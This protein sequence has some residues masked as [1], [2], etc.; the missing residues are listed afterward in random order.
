[1]KEVLK[2]K[3]IVKKA[4][5]F[6]IATLLILESG[7]T[8]I[9]KKA[10][11]EE[12]LVLPVPVYEFTFEEETINGVQV[13][14]SDRAT[15]VGVATLGGN[16]V[17]VIHDEERDSQVLNL[18]GGKIDSGYLTLPEDLFR[19][20]MDGF[21]LC[22]WV[23]AQADGTSGTHYQRI[24][25]SSST[26]LGKYNQGITGNWTDP[27]FSVVIGG[28]DTNDSNRYDGVI[29]TADRTKS[30]LGF[31]TI[32]GKGKWQYVTLSVSKTSYE[33]YVN[34]KKITISDLS[35]NMTETL[36][37][38]FVELS[39]FKYNSLGQSVYTSD[40]NAK[41]KIDDFRFYDTALTEAEAVSIYTEEYGLEVEEPGEYEEE[42]T[43]NF[44]LTKSLGEM[45]H[46]STGF[47]YGVSENNVPSTDLIGAIKPKFLVQKAADGKQ[48]PSGDAYR[49]T[50]Y[51]KENG[52][53]NLQVYLQDY[54]LQWPYDFHGIEDYKEKVISIV[55]KMTEGKTEEEKAFYSYVLFNEP[56]MI[57]YGNSGKKLEEF[58][59][60]W[61]TIYKAIKEIDKN[62][63]VAGPNFAGYH[64]AAYETF[65][66]FCKENDCLPE[67][68]TWHD[69]QKDKLTRF[70][71]E[72]EHLQGLIDT[73][74]AG[75]GIEPTLFVNEVAN[76]EDVG[77]PGPLVNW[78]SI[79]EEKDVYAALP[80]WGLANTL[81]ELA[82]DANKPNGAWWV[83]KWYADMQGEKV[84]MVKENQGSGAKGDILYGL[85]SVDKEEQMI[86][87]LF[88]GHDGTQVIRLKNI[89]EIDGFLASSN[90]N[91]KIYS[92]KYTGHHGFADD[93]PV[94]YE[95]NL[96]IVNGTLEIVL[97]DCDLLDAYF[98]VITPATDAS[99]LSV[100]DYER[101]FTKTYEAE[102]GV[103]L[104][105]AMIYN[106][107]GGADL[108]RSNR[109]EVGN[110][111]SSDDGVKYQ[112]EVPK[113]GL[114]EVEVYYSVSA[115]F[116]NPITLQIDAGG[117]NRAIGKKV[118][119]RLTVDGNEDTAQILDFVSTVKTGYYNYEKV[120]LYLTAGAHDIEV[121][122]YGESQKSVPGSIRLAA[123][124][125]KI[126]VTYVE[127][128]EVTTNIQFEEVIRENTYNFNQQ[129]SGFHGN[130]YVSGSGEFEFQTVVPEDG[131]YQVSLRS[132][133]EG[134]SRITLN[135]RAVDYA[136]DA[137]AESAIQFYPLKVGEINTETSDTFVETNMNKV[138]LTAGANTLY[139]NSESTVNL[140]E[141]IFTLDR[142]I[143]ENKTISIE[144]E[145]GVLS[146]EA[147]KENNKYASVGRVVDGIGG[148]TTANKL[149]I[150]FDAPE[151]GDYKLSVVYAN[152]EPAPM[153]KKDDGGNYVHPYNTDLIERYAQICV[154]DAEPETVYFRN[155]LSWDVFRN[156]VMDVSLNKGSN[157]ITIYNDNTYKFSEVVDDFAPQFDRFDIT[158]AYMDSNVAVSINKQTLY[159]SIL[160]ANAYDVQDYT[161][162]SYKE[163]EKARNSAYKLYEKANLKEDKIVSAI[164]QIEDAIS[165]LISIVP[166]K[167]ELE[168]TKAY[169]EEEMLYTVSSYDDLWAAVE[170]GEAVLSKDNASVHEL[171][172]CIA[173]LK[174]AVSELK[175]VEYTI[176]Y[177]NAIITTDNINPNTHAEYAWDGDTSTHPDLLTS[178]GGWDASAAWTQIQLDKPVKISKLS[179]APRSGYTNRLNGGYFEVSQDGETF[180]TI[181]MVEN[182]QDGYN[183]ATIEAET[184]YSY[185]RYHSPAHAY[186]NIS[187]IKI[188]TWILN[189]QDLEKMKK[190]LT[191]FE[192]MC[193]S[194]N[195]ASDFKVPT[196]LTEGSKVKWTSDH[197]AISINADG[198]ASVKRQK[199]VTVVNLTARVLY[200][201]VKNIF[202]FVLEVPAKSAK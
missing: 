152:N 12:S 157:H 141:I 105:E 182:A 50:S 20:E 83:Y 73:Y 125:D 22:Y 165:G 92:T 187:D 140:D 75:S 90:A 112:I 110:I 55:T 201:E 62:A 149:E 166:L 134:S 100:K 52:V 33:V 3:K 40:K 89:S 38:F 162:T 179:Y 84:E 111:L 6:G 42:P 186:L 94:L 171:E 191:E 122:H 24:F 74:Y 176:N 119:N 106:R 64:E 69:L 147:K 46:R 128:P 153:M 21:S 190:D 93:T 198:K 144:A 27:E 155:T 130:G 145:S 108:A 148:G 59:R 185:L 196:T 17:S 104:G 67:M 146:G 115:P 124:Q 70:Q 120:S 23:K 151:A 114:Y 96:P 109:A 51:L 36:A 107:T 138:Y 170:N 163:L 37:K 15:G 193:K 192:E 58:C 97:E 99:I 10:K 132:M 13:N 127:N 121:R 31:S 4:V 14:N 137:K 1:M 35:D 175:K 103:L 161:K 158:P 25:E 183:T 129:G 194:L 30:R 200:G 202:H 19:D 188:Y 118:K 131:L 54:Y 8:G 189:A 79:Y 173:I 98:A 184:E 87:S 143:T 28:G 77:A 80:Y 117:Q 48:H 199:N 71:S 135:K 160:T 154:N 7:M 123:S 139:L 116:V 61:L 53:E 66:K 47:L 2:L 85:T 177:N 39:D 164:Q 44:D 63:K 86:Y 180:E 102:E 65:F 5:S 95:G 9:T 29:N 81:N 133:T 142:E 101:C 195:T 167:Q 136:K 41:A 18:P 91:V 26:E 72:Y 168:A 32:M 76:F 57:W 178:D 156:V 78:L 68:I 113:D 172:E 45:K 126:D 56:D 197:K 159:Q 43:L 34:G 82:A 16:D 49:L 181:H 60:D 11:A 174:E 150:V 88:G 169:S